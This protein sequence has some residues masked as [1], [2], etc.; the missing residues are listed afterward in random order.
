MATEE[1]KVDVG[2][3]FTIGVVGAIVTYAMVVAAQFIYF[4]MGEAE[5]RKKN[6]DKPPQ[7]LTDYEAEQSTQL[8]S[9][10]WKDKDAKTVAIPI[11]QAIALTAKSGG[12]LPTI[13]KVEVADLSPSDKGKALYSSLGCNACHSLTG[14]RVVGPSFK[15]SWGAKRKFTDG[16][17]AVFNAE[18][19]KNSVLYPQKQIV[20]TY[21]PAMPAYEGRVSDEDLAH[22][23]AFIESLA[24]EG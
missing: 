3:V 12:N 23:S 18:Y 20:E 13:A 16:T 7:A 24:G 19:V 5:F 10:S 17:Q 15:G 4:Q 2:K 21:M 6:Y 8:S 14:E 22:I 1:D 11:E 9:Y